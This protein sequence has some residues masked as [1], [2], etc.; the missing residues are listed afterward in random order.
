MVISFWSICVLWK[1]HYWYLVFQSSCNT[2][3]ACASMSEVNVVASVAGTFVGVAA[4]SGS[5]KWLPVHDV[6]LPWLACLGSFCWIGL[7]V[8]ARG[9]CHWGDDVGCCCWHVRLA[10]LCWQGRLA[11]G[12]WWTFW[13]GTDAG[14]D[15][16]II[17]IIVGATA[18]TSCSALFGN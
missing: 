9:I 17:H 8:E 14:L 16:G 15:T 11:C 13:L 18:D 6:M 2:F 3:I 10:C 5:L 7:L 4:K 1:E 12:C